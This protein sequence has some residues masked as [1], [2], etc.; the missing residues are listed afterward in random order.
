MLFNNMSSFIILL[1]CQ[2]CLSA[3][4]VWTINSTS[5][6]NPGSCLT[7]S[8]PSVPTSAVDFGLLNFV[9]SADYGTAQAKSAV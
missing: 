8:V 4:Y 9:Y 6:T 3:P 7:D 2:I 1:V 5:I